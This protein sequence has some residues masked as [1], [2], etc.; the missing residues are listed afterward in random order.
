VKPYFA[1]FLKNKS[2]SVYRF[3]R[4]QD[5]RQHLETKIAQHQCDLALLTDRRGSPQTLVCT[6]TQA[7]Y[8]R[9][10]AQFEIDVRLLGELER[11]PINP[12]VRN[13]T[14]KKNHTKQA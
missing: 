13:A 9:R 12:P 14:V 4:R 5:L 1:E 6:K 10:L 2:E 7:C 8:E 3:R 11:L